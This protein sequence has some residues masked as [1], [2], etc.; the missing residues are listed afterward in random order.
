MR[1]TRYG[2]ASLTVREAQVPR[3]EDGLGL[4]KVGH[5]AVVVDTSDIEPRPTPLPPEATHEAQHGR[6]SPQR[7]VVRADVALDGEDHEG[8]LVE[9]VA[10]VGREGRAEREERRDEVGVPQEA[11]VVVKRGGGVPVP[12]GLAVRPRIVVAIVVV[13]AS[14]A[15]CRVRELV[16]SGLEPRREVKGVG[17]AGEVEARVAQD[18]ADAL[19]RV[20]ERRG[21]GRVEVLSTA[22][23]FRRR[24][25]ERRRVEVVERARGEAEEVDGEDAVDGLGAWTGKGAVVRRAERRG[26]RDDGEEGVVA[27]REDAQAPADAAVEEGGDLEVDVLSWQEFDDDR[28]AVVVPGGGG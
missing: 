22:V 20:L 15:R 18:L 9:H 16:E 13:A 25:R 1:R 12:R 24:G 5:P 27:D 19:A 21:L 3:P 14:A 8:L 4:D 7:D 10:H 2:S 23:G 17:P 28:D 26:V 6:L 11:R